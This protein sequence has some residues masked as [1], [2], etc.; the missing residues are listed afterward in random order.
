[1]TGINSTKSQ[2]DEAE[3][4]A[5]NY[6]KAQGLQLMERNFKTTGRGGGEVDLI[7][8]DRRKIEATLVFVEVRRRRSQRQGGA[9][10]SVSTVKRKRILYAARMYLKRYAVPPPCRFDVF[11][12]EGDPKQFNWIEAAFD[13]E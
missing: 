3:A 7:M 12:I 5:L 11:A 6:L 2:G 13:A 1:M 4:W 8:L 10:A 9:A